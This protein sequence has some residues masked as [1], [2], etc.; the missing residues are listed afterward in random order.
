MIM[1]QVPTKASNVTIEF[2]TQSSKS[3]SDA[4]LA[5]VYCGQTTTHNDVIIL[6]VLVCKSL[7]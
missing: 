1:R 6:C 3:K 5:F 7:L 4:I 2:S